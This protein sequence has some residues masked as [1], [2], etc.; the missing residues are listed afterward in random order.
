MAYQPTYATSIFESLGVLS[1]FGISETIW[2]KY[3]KFAVA[4]IVESTLKLRGTLYYLK[5]LSPKQAS[6]ELGSISL[7]APVLSKLRKAIEPIDDTAFHEFKTVALDFFDTVDFLHA[8]LRDIADVNSAYELS[9]P[10]LAADWD[11][12]E[13]EH[14]N[15][16]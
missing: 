14:W 10:V 12:D 3:E 1:S 15:D 8:G 13:D 6:A 11:S 5:D 9:K 16:Y 4:K 2:E 7:L